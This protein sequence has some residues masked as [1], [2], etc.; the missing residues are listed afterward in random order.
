MSFAGSGSSENDPIFI[1]E[2]TTHFEAVD[3]EYQYIRDAYGLKN[4]DWKL[5]KQTLLN[6]DGK[7]IDVIDIQLADGTPISLFFDITKYWGRF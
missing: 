4:R 1:S 7:Y 6:N 3:A 5:I 2:I